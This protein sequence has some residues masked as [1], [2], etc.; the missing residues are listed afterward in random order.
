MTYKKGDFADVL[1]AISLLS[2]H[3][4]FLRYSWRTFSSFHCCPASPHQTGTSRV[5]LHPVCAPLLSLRPGFFALVSVDQVPAYL[6]R[7]PSGC[8]PTA[9]PLVCPASPVSLPWSIPTS[10]KNA[11]KSPIK[12]VPS[13]RPQPLLFQLPLRRLVS[14]PCPH[15]LASCS[16]LSSLQVTLLPLQ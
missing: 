11:L 7:P 5:S 3:Y 15:Q 8:H 14:T 6:V 1:K 10:K 16:L 4:H 12:K 9:L 13:L 2:S